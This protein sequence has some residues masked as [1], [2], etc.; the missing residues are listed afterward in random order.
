MYPS[1]PLMMSMLLPSESEFS[2]VPS[3]PGTITWPEAQRYHL[4]T[5]LNFTSHYI[6]HHLMPSCT[7]PALSWSWLHH[8][9]G[10]PIETETLW[11]FVLPGTVAKNLTASLWPWKQSWA[12]AMEQY[13]TYEPVTAQST[14]SSPYTRTAP[15]G[16]QAIAPTVL[17]AAGERKRCLTTSVSSV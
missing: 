1:P 14:V 6:K 12:C 15:P 7:K 13:G 16:R 3:A 9:W 4:S 11:Y 5:A 10:F 8:S 17:W 2:V